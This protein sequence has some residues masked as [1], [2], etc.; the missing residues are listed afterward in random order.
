MHTHTK[1]IQAR[2]CRAH[3]LETHAHERLTQTKCHSADHTH[4]VPLK[5]GDGGREEKTL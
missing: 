2:S 5:E 3:T 1:H 4:E